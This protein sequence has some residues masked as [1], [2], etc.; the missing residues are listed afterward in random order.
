MNGPTQN[1]SY[2]KCLASWGP[3]AK[4]ECENCSCDLTG[5]KVVGTTIGWYCT[6]CAPSCRKAEAEAAAQ[7][8]YEDRMTRRAEQGHCP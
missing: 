7:T 8:S 5:Q 2:N 1:H 3:S 4:P 6:T